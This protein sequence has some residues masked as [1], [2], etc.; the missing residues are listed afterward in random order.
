MTI[1][2]LHTL[3]LDCKSVCT[4]TRKIEPNDMFFALKGDNFNGN[5]YALQAISKGAKYAIIDEAPLEDNP[6]LILVDDVLKTLQELAT[7]HRHYLDIP[8]IALTGSN[9][10]TTTKELINAVLSTTFKTT[11]TLGNLNNHIGVPL[12]LLSMNSHTEIGIVEMGAN[13]HKEI[14]FLCTIAQPNYGYITN[15]GKAHLEGFGSLEGVLTAKTELYRFLEKKNGLVFL[16]QEDPKLVKA[17][18]LNKTYS[19]SQHKESDLKIQLSN[20]NPMAIASFENESIHSQLI[21]DYN[22]TNI[23]AAIAIGHYFKISTKTIANA[24]K[25]YNPSNNR[26][27]LI[28]KG[29]CLIILDAY[30]ANPTSMIAAIDN[31]KQI[32]NTPKAIFLG[33]MFEVGN[34]S[35]EEH[36][37][38]VD[39]LIDSAID[40]I[41]IIGEWFYQTS[42][43]DIRINRFKTY[44]DFESSYTSNTIIKT[45]LIKGSRGMKLERILDLL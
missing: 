38:I 23:A 17:S 6:Q 30:N 32:S 35:L 22:F 25:A 7:Y 19:F 3:F 40:H 8:I 45:I 26:S 31:F 15:I 29:D 14:D 41:Y 42:F 12:T 36:Q 13:H 1:Q 24:I 28:T 44:D 9:G 43:K 20:A 33:D 2:Q 16:N 27:Q 34:T 39:Y 10:K 21:G 5:T 18:M 11:A 37:V 4:D